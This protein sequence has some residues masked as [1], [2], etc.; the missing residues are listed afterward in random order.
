MDLNP[1]LVVSCTDLLENSWQT[2]SNVLSRHASLQNIAIQYGF[3]DWL[4]L[5]EGLFHSKASVLNLPNS[6]QIRL[7]INKMEELHYDAQSYKFIGTKK[8]E[9]LK[10]SFAYNNL[11][12]EK[13]S[14]V[15]TALV[16]SK[17][18]YLKAEM[19]LFG[20]V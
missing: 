19:T 5:K 7:E 17:A 4:D 20:E 11:S 9:E 2:F 14:K 6:E 16:Y 3:E 1:D 13:K 8:F 18:M 15:L 10:S 12:F